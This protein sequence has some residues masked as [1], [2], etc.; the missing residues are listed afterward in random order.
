MTATS[1]IGHRPIK[2]ELA[3]QLNKRAATIRED[4]RGCTIIGVQEVEGKDAVW[5]ALARA[6][7]PDF[8]YDYFESADVRDITVGVLYD[9]RRAT[10][11][12]SEPAQTCTPTDYLVDYAAA[13][14]TARPAQ[15]LHP[16]TSWT[17]SS[18]SATRWSS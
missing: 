4:L 10:L 2:A 1:A 6:V 18:A 8:R 12:R 11:R 17:M 5:E 13:H 3:A 14:D 15:S 7:G 16:P 9:A